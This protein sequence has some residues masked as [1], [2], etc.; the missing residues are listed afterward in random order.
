MVKDDDVLK[1]ALMKDVEGDEEIELEEGWDS[2]K[3]YK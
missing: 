3:A 1:V 2:I